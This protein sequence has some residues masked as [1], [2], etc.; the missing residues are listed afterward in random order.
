MRLL[1]D[2]SRWASRLARRYPSTLLAIVGSL[3][4]GLALVT[5]VTSLFDSVFWRPWPLD[6][7]SSLMV[8]HT[9]RR[10]STGD[11]SGP[12]KWSYPDYKD[13]AQNPNSPASVAIYQH[14]PM[15][16]D[17]GSEPYRGYGM[18]VSGNYFSVLGVEASLGRLLL[19]DDNT[20]EA[21]PAVVLSHRTWQRHFSADR[22]ILGQQVRINGQSMTVVGVGP[23]GFRGVEV[24]MEIDLW[25]AVEQY[26]WV[27][28][29]P[30]WFDVRG[31]SFFTALTR[32]P[33]GVSQSL[34]EERWMAFAQ[35][36]E[37]E[38]PK[39]A[40]GLGVEVRPLIE[41]SFGSGERQR[42]LDYGEA[43][44][45][46]A[47]LILFVCAVNSAHLLWGLSLARRRELSI[48]VAMGASR[49]RLLSQLVSEMCL[50]G[51]IAGLLAWPAA[52]GTLRL[53]SILRP[54]SFPRETFTLALDLPI[55]V[56]LWILTTLGICLIACLS[57][58]FQ[59]RVRDVLRG[60]LAAGSASARSRGTSF[61]VGLQVALACV[62]LVASLLFVRA[63]NRAYDI[64]LGFDSDRLLVVSLAPAELAWDE[65]RSRQF[66]HRVMAEMSDL[67]ALDGV[68][69]SENRLLRGATW[70]RALY[71]EGAT[72][73]L[74][75][76]ERSVHR[77]NVVSPGFF[78]VAGIPR[79]TGRDF[80]PDA[81]PDGP[82]EAII[83]R[84]FAEVAW[85]D[86]DA[87]G[88]RFRFDDGTDGDILEVVGVVADAKY[89]HVEEAPQCFVYLPLAQH[90]KPAMTLHLRTALEPAALIPAVRQELRRLAPTMPLVDLATLDTFVD[91]DLWLDR[92]SAVS[93]SSFAFVSW[94]L[95]A[96]GIYG[97]LAHAVARRQREIGIR[98]SLGANGWQLGKTLLGT[99]SS[100]L[101]GGMVVGA[102]LS[103]VMLRS[104]MAIDRRWSELLDVP[105][106]ALLGLLLAAAAGLGFWA[107]FRRARGVDA[108]RLLRED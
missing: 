1:G 20:P 9:T 91:Q 75:L 105:G 68:A 101:V 100:A 104:A 3:A 55:F 22:Q 34:A 24:P 96:L 83:N 5:A 28:P 38:Y 8:V 69:W 43:L 70:Q 76:G 11:Y 37:K 21:A 31:T 36:L 74:V 71:P 14:W 103:I 93:L 88:Q 79:L 107:P 17:S 52:W 50:L 95:A 54:P 32:L 89:R 45:L 30:E 106:L 85:P 94:L 81:S 92:V 108:G 78:E 62:A 19:P 10:D 98:R 23:P 42:H 51:A 6:D 29:F 33:S 82:L 59:G 72:D 67:A 15:S 57:V 47:L 99:V 49:Y 90:F 48:R 4:L 64:P 2:G 18:F 63:L 97:A 25:L 60:Q 61:W 58:E 41:A 86:E 53:L 73:P 102:V 7:P 13:L 26:R 44:L 40:E 80:R 12:Y 87:V 65:E 27:G 66:Y 56:S 46:G 35:A 84:A 77:T 16:I 39:A